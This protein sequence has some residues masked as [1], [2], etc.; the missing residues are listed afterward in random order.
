MIVTPAVIELIERL[1]A[2]GHDTLA[3]AKA[4]GCSPRT[5]ATVLSNKHVSQRRGRADP[6]VPL[7]RTRPVRCP[8]CGGIVV[9]LPCLACRAL[10]E[11]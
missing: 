2:E 1:F 11:G 7:K 3:I 6:E 9:K 4:S 8:G 10:K 5:V